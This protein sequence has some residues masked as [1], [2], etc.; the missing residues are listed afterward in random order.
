MTW[1]MIS[2]SKS[3][4]LEKFNYYDD[5]SNRSKPNLSKMPSTKYHIISYSNKCSIQLCEQATH[6]RP[7]HLV[8][9][10]CYIMQR[11]DDGCNDEIGLIHD[12]EVTDMEV[13]TNRTVCSGS[14]AAVVESP[15][16]FQFKHSYLKSKYTFLQ[17][18]QS[19][20]PNLSMLVAQFHL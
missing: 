5:C 10:L 12:L 2:T 1:N 13:R 20:N 8:Q 17:N 11:R 14:S 19:S 3:C 15:G 4:Q 6:Q 16:E 9:K 7:E 18:N